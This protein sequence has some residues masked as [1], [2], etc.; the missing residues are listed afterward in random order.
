MTRLLGGVLLVLLAFI[1]GACGLIV[2]TDIY[3]RMGGSIPI[4]GGD[5]SAMTSTD[6]VE[7]GA[8]IYSRR[9]A[10][11]HSTDGSDKIGPTF[12]GLYGSEVPLEDGSTVI[13]D[14]AYLHE[15]IVD[16]SA[17]IVRGYPKA[18]PSFRNLDDRAVDD[19]I[20]YIRSLQ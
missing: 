9:C 6:P 7:R 4:A 19:L 18:M 1:L 5:D 12:K 15:S 20:A 14:E 11:C 16:P 17:R 8:A 3:F 10:G 13:A 2:A